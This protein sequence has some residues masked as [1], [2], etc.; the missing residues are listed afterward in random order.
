VCHNDTELV[1]RL[2]KQYSCLPT[3]ISWCTAWY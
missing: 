1:L 3:F 2:I